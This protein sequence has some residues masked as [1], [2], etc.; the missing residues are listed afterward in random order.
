MAW[1][2][3]QEFI[4]TCLDGCGNTAT[5]L[6][7]K[8]NSFNGKMIEGC[9]TLLLSIHVYVKLYQSCVQKL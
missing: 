3:F 8:V 7:V 9:M 5:V 1:F 2:M 4:I 6:L